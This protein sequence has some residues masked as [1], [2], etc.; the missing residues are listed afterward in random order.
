MDDVYITIVSSDEAENAN[1]NG[2]GNTINDIVIESYCGS[3]DLRKERNGNGNGRVYTIN[4]AVVDEN[5][6]TGTASCQVHVQH[7]KEVPAI[8]DG[9]AYF[10]E[11]DKSS[12]ITYQADDVQLMNYP[13]PFNGNT[14]ISFKINE[15]NNTTL[16]VYNTFGK[17]V[18]TLFDGSAEAGKQYTL[19]FSAGNLSKGIYIYHLKSGK[20]VSVVKKM[21]LMK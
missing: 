1:G 9:L 18:A 10:E 2:D 7:S 8:D 12:L 3:V 17:H 15:T 5:G 13:N 20:N 6:N 16:K 21:I 14:T 19:E 11:C 4:L